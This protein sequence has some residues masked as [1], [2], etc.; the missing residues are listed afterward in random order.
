MSVQRPYTK[1]PQ[2]HFIRTSINP[3]GVPSKLSNLK[4]LVVC[5]SGIIQEKLLEALLSVR[6]KQDIRTWSPHAWSPLHELMDCVSVVYQIMFQEMQEFLETR[7]AL[8]LKMVSTNWDLKCKMRGLTPTA[9]SRPGAS[10]SQQ[11]SVSSSPRR[12]GG[13]IPTSL[14]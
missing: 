14:K 2:F 4:C 6:V 5:S 1:P 9:T 13:E 8:L 7:L 11:V 10:A 12:S 3:Q